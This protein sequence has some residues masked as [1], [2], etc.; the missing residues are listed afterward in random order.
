MENIN[1]RIEHTT[2]RVPGL[3]RTET[4]KLDDIVYS[5][6]Y[7]DLTGKMIC[8][9]V[10]MFGG[11]DVCAVYPDGSINMK[12]PQDL[13]INH[14]GVMDLIADIQRLDEFL[15]AVVKNYK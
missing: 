6:A 11:V 1:Q 5:E 15:S 3:F 4:Y 9:H 7:D 8:G 2:G 13:A 10:K 12:M 14:K